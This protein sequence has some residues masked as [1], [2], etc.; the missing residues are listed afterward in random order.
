MAVELAEAREQVR[1]SVASNG[2]S[3]PY[4]RHARVKRMSAMVRMQLFSTEL[5]RCGR[6][7]QKTKPCKACIDAITRQRVIEA[8]QRRQARLE[9][10]SNPFSQ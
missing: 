6:I 7:K 4:T 9:R 3:G 2:T 10:K 5:C 8:E 1:A